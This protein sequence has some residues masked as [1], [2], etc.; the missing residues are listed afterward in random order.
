MIS[1][2]GEEAAYALVSA[3]YKAELPSGEAVW[4]AVK[5]KTFANNAG[6]LQL[7]GSYSVRELRQ[8]LFKRGY[9][10]I[11]DMDADKYSTFSR[12]LD[13]TVNLSKEDCLIVIGEK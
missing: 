4:F 10:L 7:E 6:L 8:Q 2:T 9:I 13:D 12:K 1:A 11:G 3:Y 5:P